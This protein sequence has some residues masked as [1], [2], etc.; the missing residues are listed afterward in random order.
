ME[1]MTV[2]Q[3]VDRLQSAIQGLVSAQNYFLDQDLDRKVDT[4]LLQE[5]LIQI[6]EDAWA[7]ADEVELCEMF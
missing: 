3:V 4:T 5:M 1:E 6:D 2:K 7:I